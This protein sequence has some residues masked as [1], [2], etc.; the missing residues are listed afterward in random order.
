MP[1]DVWEAATDS[2]ITGCG[3]PS[4]YNE[5]KY[6]SALAKKFPFIPND[7]LQRFCGGG[8]TETMLAGISNVGS[9]DAGI[10]LA[11]IF[12]TYMYEKLTSANNFA[13][14]YEGLIQR[15]HDVV[16]E[17][18][19]NVN[20]YREMRARYRP[21]PT[22]SLLIDDCIDEERDFNAG[23]ARYSWSV[24]NVAGLI[25]VIDSLLAIKNLVFEQ[26]LYSASEFI[27]Q[28]AD[29]N[30]VFFDSLKN[31]PCYGVDDPEADSLAADFSEKVFK[32][33]DEKKPYLGEAFL[34]ASIQ[35]D[36]Y[37]ISGKLVDATPDGRKKGAPLCDSIGAVHGKDKKGPTALLKSVAKLRQTLALG[38][39][40]LNIWLNK[41]YVKSSLK[42]LITGYFDLGGMQ[43]QVNCLSR[44]DMIDALAHPEKH[45]N[46][47]VRVGGYSEYFNRLST[48]IKK[49][50]ISRTEH[51][52]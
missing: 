33:F 23:G 41:S 14:F 15:I 26:A 5:V 48:E 30:E 52:V 7:D 10:N 12:T 28:L 51:L 31:C 44:E 39:P 4:F 25:N 21:Q 29:E 19:D 20:Q 3:Q 2:M 47:I 37:A 34:P 43:I 17:V 13:E 11:L 32:I 24:I 6:Q 8:C 22:R 50:V 36:T 45:E 42:P 46:L 16:L 40:V 27:A 49:T 1:D 18:L 38:T 9:L 35:F